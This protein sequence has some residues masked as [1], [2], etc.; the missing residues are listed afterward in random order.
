MTE[1][2]E[3]DGKEKE[4]EKEKE[5]AYVIHRAR[6]VLRIENAPVINIHLFRHANEVAVHIRYVDEEF[7]KE[8]SKELNIQM[9]PGKVDKNKNYTLKFGDIPTPVTFWI[10]KP[11]EPTLEPTLKKKYT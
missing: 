5:P 11:G 8:V 7:I 4:K 6:D 10:A 9:Y 3:E 2:K 1:E